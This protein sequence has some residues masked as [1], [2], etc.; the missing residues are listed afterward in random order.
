MGECAL[1]RDGRVGADEDI[2]PNGL[3]ENFDLEH[4][5]DD[6]FRLAVKVWVD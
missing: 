2:V 6:L 1:V 4:I 3:T 5:G